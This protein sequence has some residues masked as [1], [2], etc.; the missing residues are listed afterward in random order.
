MEDSNKEELSLIKG[1][2]T[3]ARRIPNWLWIILAKSL[4]ISSNPSEKPI[5]ATILSLLTSV[6]ATITFLL[7]AWFSGHDI[8]SEHTRSDILD[9]TVSIMLT[10]F[11]C[12]LGVYSQRLASRILVHPKFLDMLRLH[13][14]KVVKVNSA[15]LIGILL[16]SLSAI[17]NISSFNKTYPYNQN[18]TFSDQIINDTDSTLVNPCQLVEVQVEICQ[19][20]W[21]S[22]MI[23]SIFFLIWNLLIAVVLVSVART[24][25]IKIRMFLKELA[26]DANLLDKKLQTSE[27]QSSSENC[28]RYFWFEENHIVDLLDDVTDQDKNENTI[29][30]V[31][32]ATPHIMTNQE[33]MNKYWTISMNVRMISVALQRWMSTIVG[34]VCAWTAIRLAHWLSHTPTWYGVL[35][36]I[37][38]LLLIPLL[39]SSYA[40]VNYEGVK[41][42]QSIFPIEGRIRLFRYLYG[43]PIQ[44]T[45]YSHAV[46]Y[47]TIGTVVAGIL[48][49]F[50]SKILIQEIGAL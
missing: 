25:T 23:Y 34:L 41:A 27:A 17:L 8:V 13:S 20:F 3:I 50:T 42:V 22:Q 32:A 30:E 43:Q 19:I 48:A 38:P 28:S 18:F 40:E 5:F 26:Q 47:G 35:M 31:Q 2:T 15:F 45:V 37:M 39:A 16:S 6:S 1:K 49:A 11:F 44:M 4:G 10:S 46:S 12:C 14:K 7:N 9:G 36:L 24:Q 33:I 29:Q 21:I